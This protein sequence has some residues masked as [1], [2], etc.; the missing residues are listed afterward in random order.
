MKSLLLLFG[1]SLFTLTI[2]SAQ[3]LTGTVTDQNKEP[4]PFANVLLFNASDSSL[5]KAEVTDTTGGFSFN[6]SSDQLVFI[7]IQMIGLATFYSEPF[8]GGKEFKSIVLAPSANQLGEVTIKVQKPMFETTGRGMIVNVASS[9]ILS[10]GN[11]QEVLEKIPGMIVNQD[12]SLSLKG[13]HNLVIYM[14]GK[15]TF[16]SQ[17]DLM[18]FLQNTPASEIEK[19]EVFET[20][21]AKY[22]AAGN[23][24]IINVVRKKGKN[25]GFNGNVGGRAGYGNWHKSGIWMRG[26]YR[27][28]KANIYGNSWL[29]NSKYGHKSTR[30]MLMNIDGDTS[31]F[32]NEGSIEIH[33]KGWG[34]RAGVDYFLN[35][36]NTIGYIAMVYDGQSYVEE[37][38]FVEVTGPAESNYDLI[39]ANK[40]SNHYW[41]GQSHNINFTRDI[42]SGEAL[43]LDANF[44]KRSSG[45]DAS[46][47]NEYQRKDTSL[48]PYYFQQNGNTAATIGVVKLDYEKAILDDWAFEVGAKASWVDTRN[49]FAVHTGTSGHDATF[50]TNFSNDFNYFE[51]IYAA[52]GTWIEK[53]NDRWNFDAGLRVEH[54]QSTGYSPTVDSLFVRKYTS[55]FPNLALSYKIPEKF[56]LALSGTRRV[57]RPSYHQLNP[58]T[59]QTNQLKFSKGNPYLQP[60]YTEVLNFSWGLRDKIFFTWSASQ[61]LGE[62]AEVIE[63]IE[64]EERQIHTIQNLDNSYNFNFNSSIPLK[65]FEWWTMNYNFTLYH[66]RLNSKLEFGDVGYEITTFSINVLQQFELPQD[67]KIEFRGYYNHDSYW[68][69]YFVEPHY[70]VDFGLTKKIGNWNLSFSIKDFLNIRE[71]N[72]GMFQNNIVMPTTYKPESRLFILHFNYKF[73]NQNVKGERKRKTGSE[74]VL[75]RTSD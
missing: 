53:L 36:K 10:S 59:S 43:I 2:C 67:F 15:R 24:G 41:H 55:L 49:I 12:G 70:Q 6:N 74:D 4:T 61:T 3:N 52:Y 7:E 40:K 58:F 11:T 31:S 5:V 22:D 44:V 29:F 23:A 32:Y 18:I 34:T 39:D 64:S 72:G 54:T 68:D 33:P 65:P 20:P 35:D 71:G 14:D 8:M 21:P 63:Q 75:Q 62:M 73:G 42:E 66:N 69:F 50:D 30:D 45:F 48:T 46:T 60:Q 19:I 9:P 13:K 37:P 47:L 26:N 27:N 1:F 38:S 25:L 56:S 17:K 57:R 16:M 28:K 51:S